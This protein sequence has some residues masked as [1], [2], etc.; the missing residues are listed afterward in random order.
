M[1]LQLALRPLQQETERLQIRGESKR[2][3]E[4]ERETGKREGSDT[5]ML[6][7]LLRNRGRG[8]VF[9]EVILV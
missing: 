5:S 9:V 6:H 2:K 4:Q 1:R 7:A 3:E 8:H